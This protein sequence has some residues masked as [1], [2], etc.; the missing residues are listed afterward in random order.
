MRN[1]NNP[2]HT[3][4]ELEREVMSIIW[5][6]KKVTSR[7]IREALEPE[8]P[9]ALTTILTVISRLKKKK[10]ILEVPSLGRSMVFKAAI[11]REKVA[12]NRLRGLLK[13]F[14]RGSPSSLVAHLLDSESI[15][16]DELKEIRGILEEK[17][18]KSGKR[19]I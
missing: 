12:G 4:S 8:R 15:S 3:L 1:S 16:D 10:Y 18:E 11:P 19:R 14:F 5:E 6:K 7:E 2:Q 13:Q 17:M 9:L